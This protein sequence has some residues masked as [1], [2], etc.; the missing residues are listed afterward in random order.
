MINDGEIILT[1]CMLCLM[2]MGILSFAWLWNKYL[3]DELSIS[4]IKK[5]KYR[6]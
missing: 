1:F 6:I 3:F 4:L 2:E 5:V